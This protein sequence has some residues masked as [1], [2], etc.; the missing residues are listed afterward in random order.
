MLNAGGRV[1]GSFDNI[2]DGCVDNIGIGS[3]GVEYWT[4]NSTERST[5]MMAL[6]N[7]TILTGIWNHTINVSAHS[8]E[9]IHYLFWFT[10][11]GG[12]NL[13]S[14]PKEITVTDND[15]A[16]IDVSFPVPATTGEPFHVLV[17]VYDNIGVDNVTLVY[18]FGTYVITPT[19]VVV[20]ATSI[21]PGGNGTYVY[22][23]IDVPMDSLGPLQLYLYALD[24]WNNSNRTV[25]FS[26]AVDDNDLPTLTILHEDKRLG[27]GNVME[28]IVEVSDNTGV[29]NVW[30]KHCRGDLYDSA[31]N[32]SAGPILVDEGGNGTYG[33]TV[34]LSDHS[35][36]LMRY[37]IIVEDRSTNVVHSVWRSMVVFDDD[38]PE[39][40]KDSTSGSIACG[41]DL[42]VMV[43]VVD[44]IR[45]ADVIVEYWFEGLK[46][47]T[48]LMEQFEIHPHSNGTYTFIIITSTSLDR[49]LNYRF[50]I[51]D[52]Q[53]N[54]HITATRVVEVLDLIPPT[55]RGD[56]TPSWAYKG[57]QITFEIT[58][59][60]NIGVDTVHL[61]YWI[62]THELTNITMLE[63]GTYQITV[64]VPRDSG[65]ELTY[66]FLAV[67]V[68]GNWMSLV[69]SAVSLRNDAPRWS[70]VPVWE[71]TEDDE[72]R[73]DLAEY[74]SDSNDPHSELTLISHD[75]NISVEGLALKAHYIH[76]T[77]DFQFMVT[78]TDGEDHHD[79]VI[80]VHVIDMN[81]P[82]V[83][84][85]VIYPIDGTVVDYGNNLTFEVE[86]DDPD[87]PEGQ[88]IEVVWS[89]NQSGQLWKTPPDPEGPFVLSDLSPGEHMITATVSDGEFTAMATVT[90][91]VL[92]EP[93]PSD[94]DSD[95]T[96][97]DPFWS[98]S[99]GLV[100]LAIVIGLVAV[101]LIG[102]ALYMKRRVSD[103]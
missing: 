41:E 15:P 9:P 17:D 53:G 56:M 29:S 75:E 36:E 69:D 86:Y 32:E 26:L 33:L 7:G 89:S 65:D 82:P 66:R 12:Y 85:G 51:T 100:I 19:I 31:A 93:R 8:T 91:T 61:E 22:R 72:A 90:V 103:D 58:V 16:S 2:G 63:G 52:N 44:N 57:G 1:Y 38:P 11:L 70:N 59:M 95:G 48:G 40:V 94:G 27:T 74:I 98:T 54:S 84:L 55:I 80:H 35:L 67:D 5:G 47:Q 30:I 43:E 99:I 6:E 10:D 23:G 46:P 18:W 28:F 78:V 97:E 73:L 102:L 45:I 83:I 4:G 3:V 42:T 87:I 20:D 39:L 25:T 68:Y 14:D 88:S 49:P 101:A 71:V 37:L 64:E 77:P 96:G 60:D 13:T 76:W 79:K 21:D 81:D 92:K 34:T 50:N 24:P 62:G